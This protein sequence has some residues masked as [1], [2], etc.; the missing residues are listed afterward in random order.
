MF[1]IQY[2]LSIGHPFQKCFEL[3]ASIV[4]AMPAVLDALGNPTKPHLTLGTMMEFCS[5]GGTTIAPDVLRFDVRLVHLGPFFSCRFPQ[6]FIIVNC[7][8]IGRAFGAH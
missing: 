7:G 5:R 1:F 4:R 2:L 6:F 3:G 8:Q